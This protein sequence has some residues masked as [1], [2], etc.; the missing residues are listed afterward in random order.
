MVS[1][2]RLPEDAELADALDKLGNPDAVTIEQVKTKA[3]GS[4]LEYFR[5]SKQNSRNFYRRFEDCGYRIGAK[6]G[7][8]EGWLLERRREAGGHLRQGNPKRA[9]SGECGE[10]AGVDANAAGRSGL[11]ASAAAVLRTRNRSDR[12]NR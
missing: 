7:R 5:N 2:S 10:A 11:C 6:P 3:D 4:L 1:M 8:A 9:R 12:W